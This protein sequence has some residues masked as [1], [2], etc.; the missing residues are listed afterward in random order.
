MRVVLAW[1]IR[2]K[3]YCED[4]VEKKVLTFLNV[5]KVAHAS[6]QRGARDK[7]RFFQLLKQSNSPLF[8]TATNQ[9]LL[10]PP[11]NHNSRIHIPYTLEIGPSNT[12]CQYFDKY[13]NR[14]RYFIT[15][16]ILLTIL[17]NPPTI[18]PQFCRF[19]SRILTYHRFVCAGSLQLRTA[20]SLALYFSTLPYTVQLCAR[21]TP[22][23]H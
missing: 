19:F 11:S 22:L 12:F 15:Q 20:P 2:G 14:H 6:S 7:C 8:S 17:Q 3:V 23:S 5:S 18:Y 13:H 4:A 10:I 16:T 21:Q 9:T 1:L